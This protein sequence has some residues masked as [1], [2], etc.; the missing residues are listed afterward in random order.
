M[1]TSA[2]GS[3]YLPLFVIVNIAITVAMGIFIRTY[4]AGRWVEQQDTARADIKRLTDELDEIRDAKL[5]KLMMDVA[6]M[7]ERLKHLERGGAGRNVER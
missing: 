7:N 5:G 3:A 2:L 6:I 4:A 1:G